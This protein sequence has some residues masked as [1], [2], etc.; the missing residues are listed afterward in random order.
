M[1]AKRTLMEVKDLQKNALDQAE[2]M[3]DKME[4]SASSKQA[5][6]PGQDITR[7][8]LSLL[9]EERTALEKRLAQ[10]WLLGHADI[11]MSRLLRIGAKMLMN[12]SEEEILNVAAEV[13][14]MYDRRKK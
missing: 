7:M 12:A 14:N 9:R 2:E 3:M 8:S 13:P 11:K 6:P 4:P 1:P 10:L 5:L